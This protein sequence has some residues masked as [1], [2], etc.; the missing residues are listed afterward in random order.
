MKE[1]GTPWRDDRDA[2]LAQVEALQ[3]ENENLRQRLEGKPGAPP[4]EDARPSSKVTTLAIVFGLL[5]LTLSSIFGLWASLR[6][7]PG[8]QNQNSQ[9]LERQVGR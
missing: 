6:T 5:L 3:R 4:S 1:P 9:S 2:A 8:P 7:Q